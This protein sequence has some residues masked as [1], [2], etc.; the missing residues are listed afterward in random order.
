MEVDVEETLKLVGTSLAAVAVAL[1]EKAL[2]A[3]LAL[4]GVEAADSDSR[5]EFRRTRRMPTRAFR[6]GVA[7]YSSQGTKG[8]ARGVA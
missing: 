5:L 6:V 7:S 8:V 1:E 3:E 4:D 2:S